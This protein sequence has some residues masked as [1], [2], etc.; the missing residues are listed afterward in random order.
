MDGVNQL[1]VEYGFWGMLIAAFLAGTF[2]PFSSEVVL[3]TLLITTDSSAVTLVAGATVGNV[4]GTMFNYALGHLCSSP[5][6]LQRLAERWMPSPD[7]NASRRATR[8]VERY[9]AWSGL[10]SFLPALGTAIA[11]VAGLLRIRKTGFFV[12]TF[13]GKFFRYVIIAWPI[14]VLTS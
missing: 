8:W 6:K 9:G 12:A 3:T 13:L 7:G 2:I 5:G 14:S 11:I 10:L 4:A 1:L